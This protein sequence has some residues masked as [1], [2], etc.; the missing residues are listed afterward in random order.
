[1]KNTK[2]RSKLFLILAILSFWLFTSC[3][4]QWH[5]S[6][7]NHDPIYGT[8]YVADDVKVDTLNYSQFKRK[9]RTDFSFRWDYANYMMNQPLSFYYRNYP[10]YLGNVH[11]F[12]WNSNQYWTD[13]AFNYPFTSFNSWYWNRWDPW[14]RWNRWDRWWGYGGGWYSNTW[15][16]HWYGYGWNH[17]YGHDSM[18]WGNVWRNDNTY[19]HVNGRRGS[20]LFADGNSNIQNNINNRRND[21]NN[22]NSRVRRYFNPDQNGVIIRNGN[23]V[24]V[25]KPRVYDN[26]NNVPNN[27]I[28]PRNNNNNNIRVNPNQNWNSNNN[29]R[30]INNNRN[31]YTPPNVNN[32]NNIRSSSPP[33]INR[34]SSNIS[35]GSS[36]S[37]GSSRGSR[38]N[39]N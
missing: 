9:L 22:S 5:L 39:N 14:P 10:G 6:T 15:N 8:V 20:R 26:P 12:W 37:G 31:Y 25:I 2:K 23:D 7:V 4:V 11:D 1:M 30:G 29:S 32:N 38:G 27:V 24:R 28:R 19:V 3:G 36:S 16:N 13:W 34:G 18:L 35:R 33:V 21:N 17:W